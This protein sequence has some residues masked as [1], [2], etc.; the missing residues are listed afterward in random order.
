VGRY[1]KGEIPTYFVQ[2]KDGR[3]YGPADLPTLNQW[4]TEGRILAD[5]VLV[6]TATNHQ[7]VARDVPG[8]QHHFQAAARPQPYAGG[9]ANW[10]N[11]PSPTPYRAVPTLN[12][13]A[14]RKS[15]TVAA[16]LA[17]FLGGLGVH[18]FYLG[19]TLTGIVMLAVTVVGTAFCCIGFAVTAVWA[20]V[21]FVL[22]L[23]G[24]MRDANG[25]ELD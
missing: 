23:I 3:Y 12:P 4:A 7:A 19:H 17:F 14:Q 8:L 5:S 25:L 1:H 11:P 9:T 20:M 15:K 22:I 10:Q 21:D 24:Q 16:L 2:G 6:D 13:Y 18:R